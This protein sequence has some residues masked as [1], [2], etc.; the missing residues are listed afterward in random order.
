MGCRSDSAGLQ[1]LARDVA[2]S[3]PYS[4][5]YRGYVYQECCGPGRSVSLSEFG[6]PEFIALEIDPSS[7]WCL[8]DLDGPEI[9]RRC[10]YHLDIVCE[11]GDCGGL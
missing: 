9:M 5:R 2:D 3:V 7:R 4:E 6:S 10:G 8:G 1:S 11:Y